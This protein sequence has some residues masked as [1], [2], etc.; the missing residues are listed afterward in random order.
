MPAGRAASPGAAPTAMV[1][2]G[3]SAPGPGEAGGTGAA[4]GS[5]AAAAGN[6]PF[7]VGDGSATA[8]PQ[9]ALRRGDAAAAAGREASPDA[10]PPDAPTAADAA[11]T[12][13]PAQGA[14]DVSSDVAPLRIVVEALSADRASSASSAP[15]TVPEAAARH[16]AGPAAPDAAVPPAVAEPPPPAAASAPRPPPLPPARQVAPIA[17]ALALGAGGAARLTVALE[18]EELGRVEIRVERAGAAEGDAATVRVVAER[19][20]TLALL[21]R[22]A[23]QLDRALQSAG[24]PVAEG[25]MQFSLAGRDERAGPGDG[26]AKSNGGDGQARRDRAG[27]PPDAVLQP[28]PS[29][30]AAAAGLALLDIAI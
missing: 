14:L 21:Q 10:P 16:A 4:S 7:A 27:T 20:E 11:T 12:A 13:R 30:R 3:S 15:A 22:D 23:R 28:V 18:P 24:I 6:P 2:D 9:A 29:P 1:R 17:I 8:A 5:P 19:P 25:A 26:G